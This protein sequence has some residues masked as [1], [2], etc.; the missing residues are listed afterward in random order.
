[1]TYLVLARKYRPKVFADMVGQE[2]VAQTLRGAISEG[3][4]GH[5][6][7]FCGPRGTGKTTTARIFAKALNCE[8]GPT[9]DP[10]GVCERCVAADDGS[11]IDIVEIDAASNTGVDDV[12]LLREQVAYAPMRARHKVYIIDEV[13]MLSKGAFNAFLKT[14]EEPPPHVKFL[15]ATTDPQKVP[16]TILSRCQVLKL[17]PIAEKTIRAR[18]DHVFATEHVRAQEG[19]SAEIARRARGGMRDALS[20][21]DQLLSLVG[22]EPTVEDV[23]RLGEGGGVEELER[24]VHAIVAHD[25]KALLL[26]LPRTE[27][28]EGEFLSALLEYVRVSLV[29]F[30][31]GEESPVVAESPDRARAMKAWAQTVGVERLQ[32]WLEELIQARERIRNLPTHS[33]AILEATLLDLC[34]EETTIGLDEIA[35]RLMALEQ[36]LASGVRAQPAVAGSTAPQSPN[37]GP[38]ATAAVSV[39]TFRA[40]TPSD[41]GP[42]TTV[43]TSSRPTSTIEERGVLQPVPRA[44]G[45]ERVS[46]SK[47]EVARVEPAPLDAT[48]A[49]ASPTSSDRPRPLIG[50]TSDAWSRFLAVLAESSSTLADA[51]RTRG[52]LAD[53]ANGRALVQL[54][55][56]RDGE[57]ALVVDARNQKIAASAFSRAV[58]S[59][60]QV[61]FED[62]SAVRAHKDP[63][64]KKI[65][66]MFDGRIEDEG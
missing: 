59:T 41:G 63:Y 40:S 7:L 30:V 31:V 32:N 17:A 28:S 15:F 3:R 21:A 33:R 18:L 34:R 23:A 10:C 55:N 57:R 42:I 37:S 62:Q 50:G 45:F 12:R 64:T 56:L 19:V 60:V 48:R 5:A 22:A 44:S 49:V 8:R 66:E 52:K 27:G 16:D 9:P 36:R 2:N 1:M 25:K 6:Y 11:E 39:P 46:P 43:P 65:A 51:L 58:G 61:V 14:L 4:V 29:V 24:V 26:A 35:S 53:F 38:S 47:N 20:M 13:H 54:A